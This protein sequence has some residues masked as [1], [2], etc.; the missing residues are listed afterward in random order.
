MNYRITHL[1]DDLDNTGRFCQKTVST[2]WMSLEEILSHPAMKEEGAKIIRRGYQ[3][4][5]G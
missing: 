4:E 1:Y 3:D 5:K 2:K